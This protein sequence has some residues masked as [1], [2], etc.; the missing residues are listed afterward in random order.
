MAYQIDSS[1]ITQRQTSLRSLAALAVSALLLAGCSGAGLQS[2]AQILS[3]NADA[4][5]AANPE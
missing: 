4:Y 2:Q 3:N 5:I 1:K